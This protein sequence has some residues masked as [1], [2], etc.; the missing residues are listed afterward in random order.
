[1]NTKDLKLFAL[2]YIDL[3]EGLSYSDKTDLM[4][5]TQVATNEE[6]MSMLLTGKARHISDDYEKLFVKDLFEM[7][8]IG[9][10][11][12]IISEHMSLTEAASDPLLKFMDPNDPAWKATRYALKKMGKTAYDMD[13]AALGKLVAKVKSSGAF[14]VAGQGKK[15]LGDSGVIK[16]LASKWASYKVPNVK[17]VPSWLGGGKVS[18][19]TDKASQ[20]GSNY[21][22]AIDALNKGIPVAATVVA[23]LAALLAVKAYKAYFTKA[24]QQCGKFK[25]E[26]RKKCVAKV[27]ADAIKVSLKALEDG[28]KA[29]KSA[30]DPGKC[31]AKIDQKIHK[32]K[33]EL[34]K[35]SR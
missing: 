14:S 22:Q 32:K 35:A 4:A 12:E 16:A 19:G 17:S 5:F 6:V 8:G 3:Q 1:M 30:K 27:K 24:G 11:A 13:K 28:K 7:T 15:A 26:E 33:M 10:T 31:S 23:A 29:C 34:Q 20:W 2:E 9:S 18:W 25:G 21:N